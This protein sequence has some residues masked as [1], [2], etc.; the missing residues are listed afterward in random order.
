MTD[1]VRSAK[2]GELQDMQKRFQD[3]QGYCTTT[4]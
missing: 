1:A 2:E 4:G 3:Y